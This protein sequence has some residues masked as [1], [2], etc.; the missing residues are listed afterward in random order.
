MI[1]C[2]I[3]IESIGESYTKQVVSQIQEMNGAPGSGEAFVIL[4]PF[5]VLSDLGRVLYVAIFNILIPGAT[6]LSILVLQIC[7]RLFLI[8]EKKKWKNIVSFVLTVTS[9]LVVSTLLCTLML[10][11]GI[12]KFVC[13]FLTLILCIIYVIEIVKMAKKLNETKREIIITNDNAK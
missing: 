12:L 2:C 9:A 13:V 5:T 8:G 3:P 11:I 4:M 6:L 7:A 10:S 1:L